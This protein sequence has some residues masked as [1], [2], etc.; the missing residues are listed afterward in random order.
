MAACEHKREVERVWGPQAAWSKDYRS[1][2]FCRCHN[3]GNGWPQLGMTGRQRGVPARGAALLGVPSACARISF[4]P[5][6]R[7]VDRH[8]SGK[9]DLGFM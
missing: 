7:R 8:S 9:A 1:L 3:A 4:L 2:K 6:H 5:S